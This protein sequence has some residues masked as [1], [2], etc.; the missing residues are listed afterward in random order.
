MI[1]LLKKKAFHFSLWIWVVRKRRAA[2]TVEYERD[3]GPI[4]S[5]VIGER[6]LAEINSQYSNRSRIDDI[7]LNPRDIVNLV[8]GLWLFKS[9]ARKHSA[10]SPSASQ[11]VADSSLILSR[12]AGSQSP[13]DSLSHETPTDPIDDANEVDAARSTT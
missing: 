2:K 5:H 12:R 10:N 1:S 8:T 13:A 3:G 9:S 11:P 6:T 7:V 4:P